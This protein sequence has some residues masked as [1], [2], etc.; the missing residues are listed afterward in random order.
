V[1]IAGRG[2]RARSAASARRAA[3][4]RW[5]WSRVLTVVVAAA[6]ALLLAYPSAATWFSAL[7]HDTDVDGY[8]EVIEHRTD[9]QNA[10]M[11]AEA[12]AFNATLPTGPLRD[13]YSAGADR[14]AT[15]AR[16]D[17]YLAALRVPGT[18]AMARV[19]IPSIGVDL[20]VLHGT[21]PATLALGIGHLFGSALP[22][23]GP[24]THAVLTGHNGVV[25]AT[26]FDD[27]DRLEAGDLVIVTVGGD[28]L[29]YAVEQTV[30]VLPTDTS[31][32]EPVPGRDL[33]SL[34]TCTPTG[35]NSHRL[36][37]RAERVSMPSE[38]LD[39]LVVADGSAPVGPPWWV[40]IVIGVPLAAVVAVAPRA[41]GGRP[42]GR[43]SPGR[44]SHAQP[45]G[46][47][48]REPTTR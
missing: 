7:R 9:A 17:A 15:D 4:P 45:R 25:E 31:A 12:E 24:G 28:D 2:E 18:A 11:I 26:F 46:G 19:R 8:V 42:R 33:L 6:G 47:A 1:T 48:R 41:S 37:V 14:E 29:V 20:P 22:V 40:L 43:R 30:T 32:L 10:A 35:I 34:V 27:I 3:R 38:E 44:P 13:P 39:R 16:V 5:G 21:D 23:G 36:I